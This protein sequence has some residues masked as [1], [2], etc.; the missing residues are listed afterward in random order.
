M[1]DLTYPK[2]LNTDLDLVVMGGATVSRSR[3]FSKLDVRGCSIGKIPEEMVEIPTLETLLL[4]EN[5]IS[6]VV[7]NSKHTNST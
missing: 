7:T 5:N 2:P 6:E 4:T 3:S 1:E